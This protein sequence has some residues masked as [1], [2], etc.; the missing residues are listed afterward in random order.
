MRQKIRTM[1]LKS[2]LL[3]LLFIGSASLASA[4]KVSV[5]TNM[6][7]WGNF[8]TM[9]ADVGVS[10]SQHFSL[11]A[12]GRY[13]PWSF[14]AKSSMPIY[15]KQTTGYVGVRYWPWYVWSGWWVSAK[16]R[17]TQF[18]ETGVLRPKLFEGKSIGAGLA[19]GYTWMLSE[20]F[21]IEVGGGAWA[22]RHLEFAQYRTVRSMELQDS[23]PRNFAFIDEMS[24]SLMYVF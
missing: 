18:S 1:L 5:S 19:F 22:G 17:Y 7:E 2:L 13:N 10:I 24:L 3:S 9:N 6:L 20:H 16:V 11:F 4:Q 23:G 21:N 8:G 14:Q 15:N 12:G